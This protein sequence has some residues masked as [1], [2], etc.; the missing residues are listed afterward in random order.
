MRFLNFLKYNRESFGAKI[1]YLFTI[2]LVTFYVAFTGFFIYYQS[3][4]LKQNL[5]YEGK[6]FA[7]HL[8]QSARLGVF[9]ESED[10]LKD[11]VE[12]I[13]QSKGVIL[14]QV[15][16][17][18][19]RELRALKR[20]EKAGAP[21][22]RDERLF[23]EEKIIDMFGKSR[24]PLYFEGRDR[25]EFWSPVVSGEAYSAEGYSEEEAL[26]F[27]EGAKGKKGNIIGLIRIIFTTEHMKNSL[28]DLLLK[29]IFVP[30]IFIIPGWIIAY[31]IVRGITRPLGKLTEGVKAIET[32]GSFRKIPV[33]T[34]DEIGRLATAFN[35]MAESLQKREVEKQQLEEQLRHSQKMEAIGTLAGGIA[36]DFNNT[37][38]TI[39]GYAHLLQKRIDKEDPASR[40]LDHLL[41]SARKAAVFIQSL[42]TFSRKEVYN[43]SPENLNDI[44]RNAK[45]ILERFLGEDIDLKVELSEEDLIIMTDAGQIDQVL[46]NLA[47]NARDAMPE[48]GSLTITTSSAEPDK[49]FLLSSGGEQRGRFAMITVTDTGRGMDEH[50][51]ERIFDPFFTTKEIGRGT[52]LGLSMVYGIVKQH[53]GYIDVITKP[54]MGTTF[55]IYLPLSGPVDEKKETE[56]LT[57]PRRGSETVLVAEDD[58]DL[59]RL[60][61]VILEKNGYNVIEAVNGEDAVRKFMEKKDEVEFLLL[62]VV[63][64]VK[65]G[66]EAYEEIKTI[67][68]GIKVLFTSG[69]SIEELNRK[70]VYEEGI[71]FLS[72]PLLAEKLVRK[73]REM[74]DKD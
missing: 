17:L 66:R 31:F 41:S 23:T 33:E 28:K 56:T 49:K 13:M 30:V 48:G 34:K 12:A 38:S 26:F 10:L 18:D 50:V 51:K 47:T 73:I 46:M 9:A 57:M 7:K 61:A 29:S 67:K 36:H 11:P 43:P 8:A 58:E 45:G 69:Y 59:R 55:K 2:F 63:M 40:Y 42:L 20:A 62:D 25:I 6:E 39:L 22:F 32:S 21:S 72:K 60:T 68:P 44:I 52:G 74:L 70:G 3:K 24:S 53:K 19:G 54:G 64:P 1:F 15:F 71:N 4:T 65:N 14:V 27:E 16:S 37:L 5:I 35:D